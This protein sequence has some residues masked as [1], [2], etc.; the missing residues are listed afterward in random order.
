MAGEPRTMTVRILGHEYRIRT[1]ESA[2]FVEEVARYVDELLQGIGSRMASGTTAQV[3]ILGALNIA[4][5]L[6]RLRRDGNGGPAAGDVDER[7][8]AVLE[9][10]EQV[11]GDGARPARRRQVAARA[12]GRG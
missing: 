8:R 12:G 5:E 10:L 9:R 2:E 11:A 7:V 1:D 4:E 3:A 6:F